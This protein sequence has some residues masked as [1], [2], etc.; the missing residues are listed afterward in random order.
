MTGRENFQKFKYIIK[1][2]VMVTKIL[3]KLMRQSLF[4]IFRNT[5]GSLGILIRYVLLSSI[6]KIGNNVTIMENVYLKNPEK[7][8][9]GDNVS[10]HSMCYIESN[11]SVTIGNN[12]SLAH[13]ISILS[14]SHSYHD[15]DIPIKYQPLVTK[16]T[17][18]GNNVWI[19]AKSTT[20][21]GV[22]IADGSVI[23][24]NSVVTHDTSKDSIN[25]GVPCKF[26]KSRLK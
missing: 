22:K 16:P 14:E 11:G 3:P 1:G 17:I 19:G 4:V 26:L 7:F 20:L 13:G 2:M 5:S 21:Y 8:V 10:I 9:C 24:A 6:T 18:I 12:V 23:G 25:V 15:K